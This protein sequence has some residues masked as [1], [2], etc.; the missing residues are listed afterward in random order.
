M[1]LKLKKIDNTKSAEAR[2]EEFDADTKVLLMPLD[3]QQYQIALE[4]MRRRLA[5]NDAQFGQDAVGVIEGEKTEHDNHCLLLASFIVQDWQ[6][7]QDEN[8]KPL[9]Y[10]ESICTEML[11]G[12]ANFFYFVLRRAAAIAADNRAEQDEIKGKLSP[13]SNG[14][15]NGASE[16]QSEA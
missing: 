3:N 5:R 1:A 10:S 7:A 16:P 11:C 14:S 15:G 2:W 12:D 9:A 6:G 13:A 8:G 4:R